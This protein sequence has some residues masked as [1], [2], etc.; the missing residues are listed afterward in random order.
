MTEKPSLKQYNP[1]SFFY[2]SAIENDYMPSDIS[3]NVYTGEELTNFI[4]VIASEQAN[5]EIWWGAYRKAKSRSSLIETSEDF[6]D[7][8]NTAKQ[9]DDPNGAKTGDDNN[10][11]WL[12]SHAREAYTQKWGDDTETTSSYKER[13][14]VLMEKGQVNYGDCLT[15][16]DTD[17]IIA[18]E[19]IIKRCLDASLCRNKQKSMDYVEK[20]NRDGSA[21]QRYSDVKTSFD[22]E[23]MNTVNLIA[24]SLFLGGLIFKHYYSK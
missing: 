20:M 15:L 13:Y 7:W 3:C 8:I 24:G 19:D 17:A 11:K 18:N 6:L 16:G 5:T 10:T 1:Y 9:T 22:E 2:V 12:V 4:Q 14:K 23:F 21:E